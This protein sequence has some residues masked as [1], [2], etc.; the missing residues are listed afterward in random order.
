MTEKP[1]YEELEK[2]IRQLEQAQSERWRSEKTQQMSEKFIHAVIDNLP[3]GVAVNS[4]DPAVNFTYMNENFPRIYRTTREAL[5]GSDTFWDAVYEDPE[6]REEIKRRVLEDCAS[7]DP[8]RMH[9]EDVPITR[10]GEETAFISARNIPIPDKKLMLST[11]WDVT[12]YKRAVAAL[13][14]SERKYRRIFENSVVGFFQSTPEGRFISVNPAFAKMLRYDSPEDLIATISDI[15]TQYYVDPGDRRRYQ[16]VLQQDGRVDGFE[17]M[18][19]CKDRSTIWVSNSTRAYFDETGK[20]LH[21]EGVV[22]D[23]TERKQAEQALRESEQRFRELFDN[24]SSGVAI[25]DS[26]DNGKSFVFK[27]LN[28][29]GLA[30]AQKKKNEIVGRD[31]REVFPGVESLGLFDVFKRVWQTGKS[32]HH[33]NSIYQDGRIELWVENYV[34]KLPSGELVAIYEDTTARRQAEEA[35]EKLERLVLQNQKIESIG[36]LAGG[37]A[38]DFN[39]ILYPIVGMAELLLDDLPPGSIERE[40]AYEILKAGKRG[41]DLVRQ[42]LAFSRQSKREMMPVRI[43]QI[44]KEVIRLGRSTIPSNIEIEQDIQ[45]DCGLVMADP[46]QIHQVAMNLITNAYHAVEQTGGKITVRLQERD[47]GTADN[48]QTSL[49]PDRYARLSIAD[50]G[51]GIDPTVMD[52]IFEPYFTTKGPGKGT[53]LGLSVVHGII[54]EHGGDIKVTSQ[55]GKGSTFDVFFPLV[56]KHAQIAIS[57]NGAESKGGAESILLVD[58]EASIVRLE[59]QMLERLGYRVVSR[60]SSQDALDAFKANPDKYDLVITDMN[61][62]NMTGD[63]LAKALIAIRSDLPVIICT[64]FS[65]KIDQET[66][67][68]IG[69]SGF[70]MK[71]IVKSEMAQMVRKALDEVKSRAPSRK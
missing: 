69:I 10:R 71:P 7:S 47:L 29:S 21:Y 16:Q 46:T 48:G 57:E 34:C 32:E 24:M 30:S 67:V 49:K 70:L 38:H 55:V 68:S 39:N 13:Q 2:R 52:K 28:A 20:V 1:S 51:C 5:A 12:D 53:G 50:T 63:Q 4:V 54:K 18:V 17:F 37:V 8:R 15:A 23:I 31:V 56:K 58:D 3:I 64:G 33:P 9:W 25:Y 62:P 36:N 60:I 14:E 22:S 11:V 44:L 65:E 40:N 66:A 41:R 59:K 61:M 42:I 27:D 45:I 26:P 6:F 35:K 19:R 43:Q